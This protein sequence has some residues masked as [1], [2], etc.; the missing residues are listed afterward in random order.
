MESCGIHSG[1]TSQ[2]IFRISVYDMSLKMTE[3][4]YSHICQGP[5]ILVHWGGGGG[6]G[7]DLMFWPSS[8]SS[9]PSIF[10]VKY[11]VR[12][13]SGKNM[14]RSFHH[15]KKNEHINWMQ[16]L[17]CG[18]DLGHDLDFF[19]DIS[20]TSHM[21]ARGGLIATK[22]KKQNKWIYQL[23]KKQQMCEGYNW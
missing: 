15:G 8:W 21:S 20:L 9:W 1:P 6:G 10:R 19:K 12:Y 16:G 17:I 18:H 22:P 4:D 11:S 13:I 14:V 2:D 7:A 5:M 23:N 3:Q